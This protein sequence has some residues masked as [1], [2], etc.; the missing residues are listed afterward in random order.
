MADHVGSQRCFNL[1]QEGEVSAFVEREQPDLIIHTAA[2]SAIAKCKENPRQAHAVNVQGVQEL[3]NACHATHARLIHLS[4]DQVFGG[5][6]APYVEEDPSHPLHLYGKLKAEAEQTLIHHELET[7]ILRP[8]L[9]Y[10][11]DRRFP[12]TALESIRSAALTQK[13]I[14]LFDDE[15]RTPVFLDDLIFA[16]EQFSQRREPEPGLF[17]V[18]GP[19]R[20]SRFEFGSLVCQALRLSPSTIRRTSLATSAFHGSR[21]ADLSLVTTKLSATIPWSPRTLVSALSSSSPRM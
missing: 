14:D 5:N 16:I 21:P 11:V 3:A 20:L 18:A 10:A 13:R 15:F 12:S 8:T 7:T 19:E 17:H 6:D 1:A 2:I 9:V 4:T